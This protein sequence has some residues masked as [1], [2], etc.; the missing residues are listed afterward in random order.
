[1]VEAARMPFVGI[2]PRIGSA[3]ASYVQWRPMIDT[4]AIAPAQLRLSVAPMMDW[5]E[6][7][8]NQQVNDLRCDIGA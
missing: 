7:L 6:V 1:M 8:L 4:P 3:R 5:T 2:N